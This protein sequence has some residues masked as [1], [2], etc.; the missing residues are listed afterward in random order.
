M[1]QK[2][3]PQRKIVETI[4]KY[5]TEVTADAIKS[6][7]T[8]DFTAKRIRKDKINFFKAVKEAIVQSD[9]DITA[10]IA[11]LNKITPYK[12]NQLSISDFNNN[13]QLSNAITKVIRLQ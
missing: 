11:E 7:K 9:K 4:S 3:S 5:M 2:S 13:D 8:L 6:A 1:L 12:D 10:A